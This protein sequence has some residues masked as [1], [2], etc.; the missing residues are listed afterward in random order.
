M[1]YA[2]TYA[3]AVLSVMSRTTGLY[4]KK[5]K[6]AT[7]GRICGNGIRKAYCSYH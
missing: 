6:K 7:V 3:I 1:F 2:S 4:A 5:K